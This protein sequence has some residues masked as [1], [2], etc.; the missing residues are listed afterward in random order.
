MI[1]FSVMSSAIWTIPLTCPSSSKM[2]EICMSKIVRPSSDVTCRL[3]GL[4]SINASS[5]GQLWHF[6]PLGANN[7]WHRFPRISLD[8]VLNKRSAPLFA[9]TI[10]LWVSRMVMERSIALNVCSHCSFASFIANSIS[11]FWV[12]SVATSSLT[13]LPSTHLMALSM[14]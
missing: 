2:G 14:M 8:G 12:M 3:M 6:I 1:F 4:F 13:I 9:M 5:A 7:S 11:F 10:L